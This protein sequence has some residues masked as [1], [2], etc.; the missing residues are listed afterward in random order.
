MVKW[1]KQM[2]DAVHYIEEHLTDEIRLDALGKIA[3]CSAFHFQRMF[4]YM[5]EIPLS[6]YIRRRKMTK[7]AFDLQNNEKVLDVSLKYGYDSPTA[8]NRAFQTVHGFAPSRAKSEG[9]VLKAYLPISF[10][11]SIKGETELNY[12]I[13]QKEEFRIVGLSKQFPVNAEQSFKEIP[14]FWQE[15]HQSG[16]IPQILALMDR[17]PL[18]LFGL[19]TCMRGDMFDYYIAV[20][21]SKAVPE[22]MQD[23]LVPKA[24]WAVFESIGPMP[25]AIQILQK[26]IITEW[27]P[28]S[29]YEY[30]DAP[31]V[32][33][34][35]EGDQTA[36]DYRCEV[37]LPVVKK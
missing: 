24:T 8:F 29:G 34:Y 37:W 30:A 18:G 32:E 9:V 21:S 23:Y 27:L 36:A 4:S 15:A 1:L 3:G 19:S 2:N 17:P 25:N 14:M 28:T 33:L 20:S 6:E 26:R 22:G 7:A 35:F 11:I 10:K 5:A 13:E 12:R 16:M 31:D